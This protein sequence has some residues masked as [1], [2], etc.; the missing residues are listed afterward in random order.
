M[1]PVRSLPACRRAARHPRL[2]WVVAGREVAGREEV[3]RV[4]SG[5]GGGGLGGGGLGGGGEGGSGLG[6]SGEGGGGLGGGGEGGRGD[7]G[8]GEGG[9]LQAQK[10]N[11]NQASS[12]ASRQQ[13]ENKQHQVAAAARHMDPPLAHAIWYVRFRRG[14]GAGHRARRRRGRW[15]WADGAR[16]CTGAARERR[17][18]GAQRAGAGRRARRWRARRLGRWWRRARR[19]GRGRTWPR[20][21]RRLGRFWGWKFWLGRPWGWGRWPG[22]SGRSRGWRGTGAGRGLGNGGFGRGGGGFCAV[23]GWEAP[24]AFQQPCASHPHESPLLAS[25]LQVPPMCMRAVEQRPAHAASGAVI[26]TACMA[27]ILCRRS[28][29][30]HAKSIKYS[31]AADLAGMPG[32][33]W[34]QPA[35]GWRRRRR[36][37]RQWR[38]PGGSAQPNLATRSSLSKQSAEGKEPPRAPHRRCWH[39][40]QAPMAAQRTGALPE[41]GAEPKNPR[42]DVTSKRVGWRRLL[43]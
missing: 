2:A 28:S 3:V 19:A 26:C 32:N 16:W 15:A 37:R 39:Q 9:V 10:Q 23:V 17:A 11:Q 43:G 7:G 5:L 30:R 40:F 21:R 14:C 31:A 8:A 18:G 33:G 20:R 29:P 41:T 13:L 1:T 42:P 38:C 34:L 6:G 24:A 22:R 35:A 36:R 27:F 12:K 4:G 25:L